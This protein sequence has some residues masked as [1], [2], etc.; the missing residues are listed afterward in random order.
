VLYKKEAPRVEALLNKKG[1]K[2][3]RGAPGKPGRMV[4]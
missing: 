1:W 2:V 4:V 3:G